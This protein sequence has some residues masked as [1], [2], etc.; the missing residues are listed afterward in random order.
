[1]FKKKRKREKKRS[2]HTAAQLDV[3]QSRALQ[4]IF[5]I[6]C[7]RLSVII[8]KSKFKIKTKPFIM[9]MKQYGRCSNTESRFQECVWL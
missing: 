6:S 1:M 3:A 5:R 4:L 8:E 2:L 7:V 9:K